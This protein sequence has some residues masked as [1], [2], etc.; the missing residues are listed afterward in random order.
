MFWPVLLCSRK[1]LFQGRKESASLSRVIMI[2]NT[3]METMEE[4]SLLH[5]YYPAVLSELE[6]SSYE[7]YRTYRLNSD[8]KLWAV[9]FSSRKLDIPNG[10]W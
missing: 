10:A 7:I 8:R 9:L 3:S 5:E 4:L 2:Q 1:R 6:N